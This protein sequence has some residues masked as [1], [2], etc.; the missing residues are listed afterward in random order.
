MHFVSVYILNIISFLVHQSLNRLFASEYRRS[1]TYV[2]LSLNVHS[3]IVGIDSKKIGRQYRPLD[4][5]YFIIDK[6]FVK[7]F[8]DVGHALLRSCRH[9][10]VKKMLEKLKQAIS[11]Q[12]KKK[13]D[14]VR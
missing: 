11:K 9:A 12:E 3:E 5:A 14:F 4:Y 8:A 1:E 6:L 10:F 7:N 13:D 2:T